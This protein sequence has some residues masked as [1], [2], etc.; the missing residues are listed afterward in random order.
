MADDSR[1]ASMLD[2]T[3]DLADT[4]GGG[5]D[6]DELLAGLGGG[7]DGKG[8]EEG[9]DGD[10]NQGGEGGANEGEDGGDDEG[11][12]EGGEACAE[13]GDDE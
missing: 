2:D 11:G 6:E 10:N 12:E 5:E 8:D 1:D 13:E 3:Q 7:F 4:V 9:G